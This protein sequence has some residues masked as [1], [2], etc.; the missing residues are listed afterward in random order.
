[1]YRYCC[2]MAILFGCEV[3]SFH[4]SQ[5]LP[6]KTTRRRQQRLPISKSVTRTSTTSCQ[7]ARVCFIID[8]DDDNEQFLQ[9]SK[10]IA[11]KLD[12]PILS[13][14]NFDTEEEDDDC[15]DYSHA[16][17]LVSYNVEGIVSTYALAIQQIM[18]PTTTT[19]TTQK[20]RRQPEKKKKKK[21][22]SN[23]SPPFYIDLY[24]TT[25]SRVGRRGSS[26]S[27]GSSDLLLKAVSPRK[28]SSS[29]NHKGGS[30]YI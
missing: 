18:D 25:N 30:N 12:L 8:D 9:Q 14:S 22:S 6:I 23:N 20:R 28:G 21:P 16:L 3:F 27:A 17:K 11:E 15:N 10:E 29:I 2:L 4:L 26:S 19:T 13:A 24:P 1:M 7:G 5:T